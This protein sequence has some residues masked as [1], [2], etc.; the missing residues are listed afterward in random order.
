M[1]VWWFL[2]RFGYSEDEAA[3]TKQ[4]LECTLIPLIKGEPLSA[5][6]NEVAQYQEFAADGTYKMVNDIYW[7]QLMAIN[8][9][10]CPDK[11]K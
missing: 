5:G 8:D 11:L 2:K 9:I 1:C 4:W 6:S 10:V 7:D 3:T